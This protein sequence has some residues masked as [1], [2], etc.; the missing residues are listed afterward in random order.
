MF[1]EIIWKSAGRPIRLG[2]LAIAMCFIV[3]KK[4][5][6]FVNRPTHS[7]AIPF[8]LV[9]FCHTLFQQENML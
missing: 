2:L 5:D 9:R 8:I 1:N 4:M 3:A 6:I 7:V